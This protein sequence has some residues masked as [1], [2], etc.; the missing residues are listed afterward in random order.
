M[1]IKFWE[2]EEQYQ[3]SNGFDAIVQAILAT[4]SGAI[5]A[6]AEATAAVVFGVGLIERCFAMGKIEPDYLGKSVSPLVLSR[7]AR[8]L[9]LTGNSV[10]LIDVAQGEIGLIPAANYHVKGGV[11]ESSWRYSVTLNGPSAVLERSR[12]SAAVVHVRT[13]SSQTEPWRGYSPLIR[14]GVSAELLSTIEQRMNEEATAKVGSL[15]TVPDNTS[16]D[17]VNQLRR[18]V[19]ALKGQIALVETGSAG[20]GQGM[21]AAPQVDW[22]LR[23]IGAHFPDT[24]IQ[25]RSE[26][27]R[28]IIGA[29]GIPPSLYHGTDGVSAREAYRLLLVSTLQPIA[30]IIKE[31]LTKKLD[32]DVDIKFTKLQAADI[33]SRAR[34]YGTMVQSGVDEETALAI[35]GLEA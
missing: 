13:G 9:S 22:L 20:H 31:E 18:D 26:V 2:K 25:L 4:S 11:R 35:S 30:E 5:N 8:Q 29:L 16:E 33:Q 24:N 27:S 10:H 15:L 17:S 32:E 14:A 6:R 1:R 7:M 28:D 12:P 23:R 19:A 3:S 34:A 21:R